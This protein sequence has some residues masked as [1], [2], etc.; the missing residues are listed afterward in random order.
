MLL[1]GKLNYVGEENT[2]DILSEIWNSISNTT[3]IFE[4]RQLDIV[5]EFMWKLFS[6]TQPDKIQD[7]TFYT[8]CIAFIIINSILVTWSV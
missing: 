5:S 2:V 1:I 4:G 7:D 3:E 6:A 8:V